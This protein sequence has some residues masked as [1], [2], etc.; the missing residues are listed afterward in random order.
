MKNI[1]LKIPKTTNS[2]KDLNDASKLN[3]NA[4]F[5]TK[6]NIPPIKD[7]TLIKG[8][9]GVVNIYK[10]EYSNEENQSGLATNTEILLNSLKSNTTNSY[11]S[12]Q[13]YNRQEI[14]SQFIWAKNNWI[15]FWYSYNLIVQQAIELLKYDNLPTGLDKYKLET[16]LNNNG[17][18]GILPVKEDL[19]IPVTVFNAFEDKQEKNKEALEHYRY[20]SGARPSYVKIIGDFPLIIKPIIKAKKNNFLVDRD[21]FVIRNDLYQH[22]SLILIARYLQ[23][24]LQILNQIELNI[25]KA[26]PKALYISDNNANLNESILKQTLN[27]FATNS[28]TFQP[29]ILEQSLLDKMVSMGIKAPYIPIQFEDVTVMLKGLND[30]FENKIKEIMGHKTLR[31]SDKQ[32]RLVTQEIETASTLSDFNLEHKINIRN[33]DLEILNKSHNLNIKVSKNM[34]DK[35]ENLTQQDKQTINLKQEGGN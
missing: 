33:L 18:V 7:G 12:N 15:T 35:E 11:L 14:S 32:Q 8:A 28:D 6:Y 9:N 1:G 29:I 5:S 25:N 23:D 4:K 3:A 30:Y 27:N 26:L 21:I 24:W 20:F 16:I 10:Q 17:I 2:A 31:V 34:I 13:T 19:F 22:S